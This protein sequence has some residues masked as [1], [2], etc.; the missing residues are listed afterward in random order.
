MTQA[1][2]TLKFLLSKINQ[3]ADSQLSNVSFSM[4]IFVNIGSYMI[5]SDLES[6]KYV[7]T[8]NLELRTNS[9]PAH[10]ATICSLFKLLQKQVLLPCCLQYVI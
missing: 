6:H 5:Y 2:R 3:H 9:D 10:Q 4:Q 8:V 7:V 1:A